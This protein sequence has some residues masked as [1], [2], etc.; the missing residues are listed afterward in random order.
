MKLSSGQVK[1]WSS[2]EVLINHVKKSQVFGVCRI[3]SEH[4]H[5]LVHSIYCSIQ[6]ACTI[7]IRSFCDLE[8]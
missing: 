1:K 4:F 2:E 3:P 6:S 7:N 8:F 5:I